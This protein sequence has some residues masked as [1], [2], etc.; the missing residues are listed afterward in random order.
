MPSQDRREVGDGKVDND[1]VGACRGGG[2]R[3][4]GL[5]HREPGGC[6]NA[7]HGEPNC[8]VGV[9]DMDRGHWRPYRAA[10]RGAAG[11]PPPEAVPD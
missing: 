8:G 6:E 1:E 3:V 7:P 10:P 5:A 11:E 2:E 9:D 4:R